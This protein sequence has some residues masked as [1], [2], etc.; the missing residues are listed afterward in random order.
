VS[1]W[2]LLN[3]KCAISNYIMERTSQILMIWW[4]CPLCTRPTRWVGFL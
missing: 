4:W 1:E 3:D 2:L